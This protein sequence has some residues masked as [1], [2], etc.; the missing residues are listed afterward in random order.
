MLDSE[1]D[2]V[3]AITCDTFVGLTWVPVKFCTCMYVRLSL[4]G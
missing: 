1:V 3:V 2:Q 4:C